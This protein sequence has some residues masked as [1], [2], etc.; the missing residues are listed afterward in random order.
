VLRASTRRP[1][2]ARRPGGRLEHALDLPTGP[3]AALLAA[4]LVGGKTVRLGGDDTGGGRA[5]VAVRAKD[6]SDGD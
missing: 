6:T 3:R 4:G 5:I 2:L 1:A